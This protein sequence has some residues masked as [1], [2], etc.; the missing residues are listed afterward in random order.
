[1]DIKGSFRDFLK[2]IESTII[3]LTTLEIRTIVGDYTVA[4]DDSIQPVAGGEFKVIYSK[5]NLLDGDVTTQM[6]EPLCTPEY[7]WLREFHAR[8][9]EHGHEIINNN[10]KAIMSLIELYKSAKNTASKD[11]PMLPTTDNSQ[12]MLTT[13]VVANTEVASTEVMPEQPPVVT[14]YNAPAV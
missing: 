2:N 6:S 3:K 9:E 1:M 5:I 7:D 8:K 4:P 13:P 11:T 12:N 14:D 10:I